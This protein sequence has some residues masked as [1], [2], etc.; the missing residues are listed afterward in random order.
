MNGFDPNHFDPA[1]FWATFGV[2]YG[3]IL[4]VAIAI[5]VFICYLLYQLYLAIPEKHRAMEPA[6]VWL[7]LIPCFNIVWIFW[8]YPGL[9]KSFKSYFDSAS[10]TTVGDCGEKLALWYCIC[11]VCSVIPCVGAISGLASLV[12]LILFLIKAHELKSKIK[13]A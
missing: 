8:V 13:S 5:M 4:V 2:L 6:K 7:L 11:T 9:A 10:D 1:A 3:V 12:L